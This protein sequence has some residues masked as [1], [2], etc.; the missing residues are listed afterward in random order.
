M[1]QRV[2]QIADGYEDCNDCD[3]L[4]EDMI[5]KMCTGRLPQSDNDLASQPTALNG[6]HTY[7]HLAKTGIK[8]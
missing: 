1:T 2:F 8:G 6:I 5:F 7:T 3:D 4:R